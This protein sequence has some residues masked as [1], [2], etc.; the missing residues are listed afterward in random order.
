KEV[1]QALRGAGVR[2]KSDWR[3]ERPGFKYNHW[4][5]KGV[6]I[7]I[8]IGPRDAQNGQVV[9]VPRT[10]RTAKETCA[11]DDVA[12]RVP[13]LL[14]EIQRALYEQ[15]LA[16]RLSRTYRASNYDE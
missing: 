16:F 9:L 13:A 10:D 14:D 12:Q 8:E 2:V 1:E 7:R 15:A 11:K 6:P 5:L 4:E 3:E